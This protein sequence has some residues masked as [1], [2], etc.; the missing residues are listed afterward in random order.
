MS[1]D[2]PADM[3]LRI[4]LQHGDDTNTFS[5]VIAI[6]PIGRK[7]DSIWKRQETSATAR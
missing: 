3:A 1:G 5:S 2:W 4:L 6:T 7:L